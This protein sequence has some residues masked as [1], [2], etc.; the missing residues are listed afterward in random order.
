MIDKFNLS[1]DKKEYLYEKY[2]KRYLDQKDDDN[3]STY[4]NKKNNRFSMQTVN[5]EII[6]EKNV[7]VEITPGNN[8][9]LQES[10]GIG[11]ESG[12]NIDLI[13]EKTYSDMITTKESDMIRINELS[14]HLSGFEKY[15]NL[16]FL[17]IGFRV[18][19]LQKYYEVNYG[20]KEHGID[21][22]KF[23]VELFSM[24]G[25]DCFE[26][27]LNK[28]RN[29]IHESLKKKFDIVCC[30][31]VLEHLSSPVSALKNIYESMNNAGVLHIEIP[32]EQLSP[33]LEYGHLIGYEPREL[34]KMLEGVGF[35]V[36]SGTNKTHT[37]GS[38][39]ERYVAVK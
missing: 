2:L 26:Y 32:I 4:R 14:D 12:A 28:S 10:R 38:W 35:K 9:N 7:Y 27:D 22:N 16:N 25:F 36:V 8:L 21:V 1:Q 23:N 18:P 17:E 34:Q 24:L 33:Q 5:F 15:G 3:W 20:F 31:H 39:I 30:Y 13:L 11:I 6:G 29:K 37:G 19:K